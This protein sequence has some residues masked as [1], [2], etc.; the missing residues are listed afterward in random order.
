MPAEQ[1]IEI[2]DLPRLCLTV[3]QIVE[4]T[5][6]DTSVIVAAM[7]AGALGHI[8][9]GRPN[10]KDWVAPV[11]ELQDWLAA[12]TKRPFRARSAQWGK[13][14]AHG[15]TRPTNAKEAA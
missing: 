3:P 10:P 2:V 6:A 11:Q 1:V 7:R 15:V 8:T 5:G 9:F 12:E 4:A 13:P 14:T